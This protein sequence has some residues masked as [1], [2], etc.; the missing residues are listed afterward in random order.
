LCDKFVFVLAFV[1]QQQQQQQ[2]PILLVPQPSLCIKQNIFLQ[3]TEANSFFI[4]KT[5]IFSFLCTQP[6]TE[7]ALPVTHAPESK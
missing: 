6:S 3:E 4:E 2:P 1:Q 5:M 7:L